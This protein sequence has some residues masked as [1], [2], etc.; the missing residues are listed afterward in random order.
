M[1]WSNN[2]DSATYGYDDAGRLTRAANP[3]STVTRQYDDAGRMILDQQNVT[4]LGTVNVN[5]PTY[6]NDGRL[7]QMNVSNASY[8]YTYSYDAAGRFEKIKLTSNGSVIFQYYY[9]AASNETQ[10]YAYLPN[11]VT[12]DQIYDRDSLNRMSSR[13]TKR[14]GHNIFHRRLTPTIT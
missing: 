3:N 9:D 4:G 8:D 1:S 7:T 13:L 11:S 10:R 6:D 12:I 14:N 5:Y 2:A